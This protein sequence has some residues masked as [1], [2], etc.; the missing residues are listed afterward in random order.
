SALLSAVGSCLSRR[1]G[2]VGALACRR[3]RVADRHRHGA[4]RRS[5]LRLAAS[6]AMERTGHMIATPV[7]E[8]VWSLRG[9]QFQHHGATRPTLRDITL[10]V[11]S[12]RMTA[13]LGPN[14]AGKSTL[15]QI[16]L[17]T[18]TPASGEVRFHNRLLGE[19]QRRELAREIG[20]V[21]QGE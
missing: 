19:W 15:L 12:G 18:L 11:R 4:R 21:P 8:S 2:H 1:G 10:D 3:E 13:V 9:V 17:G 14:G 20:V 5:L 6:P 7:S 16:L